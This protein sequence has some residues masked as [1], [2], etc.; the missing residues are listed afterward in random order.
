MTNDERDRLI[1]E[2]SA[3][4]DA[5]EN[6]N[7][8]D[9]AFAAFNTRLDA[10][11]ANTGLSQTFADDLATIR[12]EVTELRDGLG[13][14][15]DEFASAQDV[16]DLQTAMRDLGTRPAEDVALT[17]LGGG[18]YTAPTRSYPNGLFAFVLENYMTADLRRY[19]AELAEDAPKS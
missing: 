10:L 4:V 19:A 13:A 2:L 6:T 7:A 5:L 3:K 18:D 17:T 8:A 14:K 12:A 11:E 16:R 15:G 9:A 1:T